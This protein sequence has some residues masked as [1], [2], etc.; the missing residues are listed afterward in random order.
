VEEFLHEG[1]DE[2]DESPAP[3]KP[4]SE[5]PLTALLP[6]DPSLSPPPRRKTDLCVSYCCE[7][8]VGREFTSHDC[9]YRRTDRIH[10]GFFNGAHADEESGALLG[11]TV[12]TTYG[13]QAPGYTTQFVPVSL[14]RT[15]REATQ[16]VHGTPSSV[17]RTPSLAATHRNPPSLDVSSQATPSLATHANVPSLNGDGKEEGEVSEDNKEEGELS[18][19]DEGGKRKRRTTRRDRGRQSTRSVSP[20]KNKNKK[21]RKSRFGPLQLS[22]ELSRAQSKRAVPSMENASPVLCDPPSPPPLHRAQSEEPASVEP[23]SQ[24]QRMDSMSAPAEPSQEPRVASLVSLPEGNADGN[25]LA[26]AEEAVGT[27]HPF[28]QAQAELEV[29][30]VHEAIEESGVA[31]VDVD[32]ALLVLASPAMPRLELEDD[33]EE[34]VEKASEEN[35]PIEYAREYMSQFSTSTPACDSWRR[36]NFTYEYTKEDVEEQGTGDLLDRQEVL[37]P[38]VLLEDE[39]GR[40]T[41]P[42]RMKAPLTFNKV[43]SPSQKRIRSY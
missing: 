10:P 38:S 21:K 42:E 35:E 23:P 30:N 4:G 7:N 3:A 33:Q 1:E 37:K 18:P 41:N 36:K 11:H 32:D 2:E 9:V 26:G 29:A 34:K 28:S 39:H 5:E 12:V 19:T 27:V 25:S 8:A 31:T 40:S 17:E 16:L 24:E 14:A 15:S 20:G 22:S 6:E 43:R 13:D